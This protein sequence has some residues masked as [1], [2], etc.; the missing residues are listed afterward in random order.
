MGVRLFH[1]GEPDKVGKEGNRRKKMGQ[2]QYIL[3]RTV[4]RLHTVI[5]LA[6]IQANIIRPHKQHKMISLWDIKEGKRRNDQIFHDETATAI[7][8]QSNERKQQT[9]ARNG[10]EVNKTRGGGDEGNVQ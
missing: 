9:G 3:W 10:T 7:S 1:R 8:D 6:D 2:R 5:T 4:P